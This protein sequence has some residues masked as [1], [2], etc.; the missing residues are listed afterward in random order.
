MPLY[1][2]VQ[3]TRN[4][5]P[6]ILV[7][8]IVVPFQQPIQGIPR[9]CSTTNS[10]TYL[11]FTID[12]YSNDCFTTDFKF[13]LDTYSRS[14]T[15]GHSSNPSNICSS[16]YSSNPAGFCL[17]NC[18]YGPVY[19]IDSYW[20]THFRNNTNT[21]QGKYFQSSPSQSQSYQVPPFQA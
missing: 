7:P 20:E 4:T 10:T 3:P 19:S 17:S 21:F 1:Q 9:T 6:Q 13:S 16:D 18:S 12:P 8:G 5:I 11:E 14:I 2:L 15:N